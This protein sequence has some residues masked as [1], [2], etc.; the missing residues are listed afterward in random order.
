MSKS[1]RID[2][3]KR[4]VYDLVRNIIY[5]VS[6]TTTLCILDMPHFTNYCFFILLVNVNIVHLPTCT[7]TFYVHSKKNGGV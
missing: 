7:E 5:A 3:T 6:N 2:S 1:S 4:Y